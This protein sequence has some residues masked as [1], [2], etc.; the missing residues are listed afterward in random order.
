MTIQEFIKNP[1]PFNRSL[2]CDLIRHAVKI[3]ERTTNESFP[4]IQE[5]DFLNHYPEG[6]SND[7]FREMVKSFENSSLNELKLASDLMIPGWPRA[8]L[9]GVIYNREENNKN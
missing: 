1:I 6:Y 4:M 7:C 5:M 3:H 2:T 9:L 8:K